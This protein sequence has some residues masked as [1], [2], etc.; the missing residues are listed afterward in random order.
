MAVV[1]WDHIS[2][3]WIQPLLIS[4]IPHI[5]SR[6]PGRILFVFIVH[7]V[8]SLCQVHWLH[9]A[10]PISVMPIVLLLQLAVIPLLV[11]VTRL[12][13]IKHCLRWLESST[14]QISIVFVNIHV[15]HVRIGALKMVTVW[16]ESVTASTAT[17]V[18]IAAK[19][20]VQLLPIGTQQLH[21]VS[22]S[23]QA[24]TTRIAT[25]VL[26][27]LVTVVVTSAMASLLSVLIVLLLPITLSISIMGFATLHVL[28]ALIPMV[29]N[30]L[31]VILL[32]FARHVHWMLLT[33]LHVVLTH[34]S[35]K[36]NT[37]TNL[38]GAHA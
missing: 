11:W 8:L 22:V 16:V 35:T 10:I 3:A 31:I 37:S 12:T 32:Y 13:K 25:L 33:V 7:L 28:M 29:F 27:N 21:H 34:L 14:V 26:A 2:T 4:D 17:M 30:V 19:S 24:N 1:L 20:V 6:Q 36:Q 5:H 15:R 23:V 38:T 9:D 18:M